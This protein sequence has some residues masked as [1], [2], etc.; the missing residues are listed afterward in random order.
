MSR[1]LAVGWPI[2]ARDHLDDAI[3]QWTLR[4]GVKNGRQ[5]ERLRYRERDTTY[6][7]P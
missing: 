1:A 6:S 5:R 4:E 2:L 7:G 3:L